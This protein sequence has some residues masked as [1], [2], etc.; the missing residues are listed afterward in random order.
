MP[1]ISR[2]AIGLLGLVIAATPVGS[3]AQDAPRVYDLGP[4]TEVSTVRVE[5][6]Q[7]REYMA[8]LN[9][10]WRRG[11]EEDKRRG[12]V[13]NYTIYEPM[14]GHDADGNLLLVVTYRNAA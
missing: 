9:G 13:L 14:D 1:M 7:L 8:Y 5:P 10:V 11:M 4:V 12:E 2:S 6:G 3:N